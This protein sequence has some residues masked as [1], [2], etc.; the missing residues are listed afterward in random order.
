MLDEKI[1]K[2]SKNTEII[3]LHKK[4]HNTNIENYHP[5]SLLSHLYKLV[6]RAIANRLT[7]KLNLYLPLENATFKRGFGTQDHLQTIKGLTEKTT[8]YNIPIPIV[9]LGLQ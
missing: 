2:E 5:I 8:E 7:N 1:P 6:M 4:G 3:I 9:F